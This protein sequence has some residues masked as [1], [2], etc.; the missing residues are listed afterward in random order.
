[1]GTVIRFPVWNSG[2]VRSQRDVFFC[3][4]S[5]EYVIAF[6]ALRQNMFAVASMIGTG[7]LADAF[8]NGDDGHPFVGQ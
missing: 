2:R 4:F 3:L 8:Q 5:P 7:P 6:L 1:M